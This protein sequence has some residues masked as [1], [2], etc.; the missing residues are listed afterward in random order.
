V[1]YIASTEY[2]ASTASATLS[3]SKYYY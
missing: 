3:T 1:E 2:F